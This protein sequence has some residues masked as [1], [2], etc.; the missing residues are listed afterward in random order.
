M[1]GTERTRRGKAEVGGCVRDPGGR[2]WQGPWVMA[3]DMERNGHT[4]QILGGSIQG[5]G[6]GVAIGLGSYSLELASVLGL[7][8][9][10][11]W[12]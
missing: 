6:D 12:G 9:T 11:R 1:L 10:Q 5:L 2:Y 3:V 7:P 4:C 8:G